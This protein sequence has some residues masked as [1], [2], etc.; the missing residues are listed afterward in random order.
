MTSRKGTGITTLTGSL[1]TSAAQLMVARAVLASTGSL[2]ATSYQLVTWHTFNFDNVVGSS[3][4]D[5]SVNGIT[6]T[7][8]GTVTLVGGGMGDRAISFDGTTNYMTYP[9]PNAPLAATTSF[10]ACFWVKNVVLQNSFVLD[11]RGSTGWSIQALKSGSNLIWRGIQGGANTGTSSADNDALGSEWVHV[12]FVYDEN[13]A[14]NWSYYKNGVA[15][16]FTNSGGGAG[17]PATPDTQLNFGRRQSGGSFAGG[18]FDDLRIYNGVLTGAEVRAIYLYAAPVVQGEGFLIASANQLLIAQTALGGSGN[19]IA[20]SQ[21]RLSAST[22]LVGTGDLIASSIQRLVASAEL[23]GESSLSASTTQ[24]LAAISLLSAVGS[25]IADTI[26]IL[27]TI[28]ILESESS[29]IASSTL[30]LS[31]EASLMGEGQLI[32]DMTRLLSAVA[33]ISGESNL[34]ADATIQAGSGGG[35]GLIILDRRRWRR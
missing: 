21:Q 20:S 12:A 14:S 31:T 16:T 10:T 1:I 5:S 30:L 15:Q 8:F 28:A 18:N 33:T 13:V 3:A 35:K 2:T 11:C 23:A 24:A 26:Q 7:L 27:D 34:I 19:L 6:G 25:L 29:L 9:F 17:T 22:A 32:A 4:L